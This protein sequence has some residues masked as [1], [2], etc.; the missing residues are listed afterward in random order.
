MTDKRLIKVLLLAASTMTVMAGAIISP[1]LPDIDR[2]FPEQS[3]MMIKLVLTL[4]ALMITLFGV[5]MGMLADRFG[6]VRL[7]T[8]ALLMY[9][10]TGTLGGLIDNFTALL[11]SRAGLGIAVAAVMSIST[12]LIGDYFETD[13]RMRFL[14]T[15]ASFMALGGIVFLNLG[16]VLAEWSW[17]G[18][19]MIYVS[20]LILAPL[21][22]KYLIEPTPQ[23]S[24]TAADLPGYGD[25]PVAPDNRGWIALAY[26]LGLVGMLLFYMVPAQLP[27]LLNTT[28]QASS[29]VIGMAVSVVTL[30]SALVSFH[31]GRIRK[32]ISVLGLYILAHL[33]S[34]FGFT[35]VG[36]AESYVLLITG[37]AICGMGF[38]F[39]IPNGNVW[40]MALSTP[41][42]RGRLIGGFSS[43]IFLGQFL[44]PVVVAPLQRWL[45]S[46]S[47]VYVAA[48]ICSLL[49]SLLLLPIWW[50]LDAKA[51][52]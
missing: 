9:G 49:I 44:S 19:F 51:R 4:P 48:G 7:L 10:V 16:G 40:L 18:P 22:Y 39:I 32:R 45:N 26:I 37:L 1:S 12:T 33:L 2:H 13:E 29:S 24:P 41:R 14:G 27:F 34:A 46:L 52:L 15:Q 8:T 21:C 42:T 36:L 43:M 50:R 35:L 20:G 3:D 5:P 30:T 6:R 28:F 38:G 17:R 23:N 47:L 25:N 31:Y 11:L